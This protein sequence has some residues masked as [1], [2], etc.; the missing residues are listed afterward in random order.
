MNSEQIPA[1]SGG[2]QEQ[3]LITWSEWSQWSSCVDKNGVCDPTRLHSRLRK[4][5]AQRT[6]EKV[7]ASHCKQR[8]NSQDQELEVAD[9]SRSCQ[10]Q[11]DLHVLSDAPS[12]VSPQTAPSVMV[13]GSL[14][15]TPFTQQLS[16]PKQ[17]QLKDPIGVGKLLD[18]FPSSST[19]QTNSLMVPTT[20]R[21]QQPSSTLD[22]QQQL[23]PSSSLAPPTLVQL[24]PGQAQMSCSNC[25]SD[26][27][28]LL[29]MQQKVP[30]CAKIKERQDPSGCGGW[31]N[32][33]NQLCQSVGQNAFKCIHDSECL[34]EE[35]RCNNGACIPLSKRCDGHSNCYDSSDEHDCPM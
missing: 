21:N 33:Q 13:V 8:F 18:F 20:E 16:K 35:W 11:A 7:D 22:E 5:V 4:C 1:E 32:E 25:T 28:C 2:Q 29:L 19:Q 10:Q 27:I 9:C 3:N 12:V 15:A 17:Q 24:E 14:E 6:G 30:F 34:A 26:E 23:S 31:C